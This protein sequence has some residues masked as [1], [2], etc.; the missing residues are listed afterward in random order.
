MVYKTL[1]P[2]AKEKVKE[3]IKDYSHFNQL[4]TMTKEKSMFSVLFCTDKDDFLVYVMRYRNKSGVISEQS[5]VL[6]PDIP[7]WI[8]IYEKEG[9]VKV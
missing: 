1:N 3:N 2:K 5:I 4:F 6:Q 9:F 8:E 7:R